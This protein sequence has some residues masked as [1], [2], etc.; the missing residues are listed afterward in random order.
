MEIQKRQ[1][2]DGFELTITGRLDAYWSDH[3]GD[4][5]KSAI[6]DGNHHLILDLSGVNYI[7]SAG[8]RV[9]LM[10]YQQLGEIQGSLIVSEISVSAKSILEMLGLASVLLRKP[11]RPAPSVIVKGQQIQ[12]EHAK[13]EIFPLHVN[14]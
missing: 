13:F 1:I 9:L 8:V 12:S 14:G 11:D 4:E 2:D 10:Y 6:R 5:I 7:S 3:L